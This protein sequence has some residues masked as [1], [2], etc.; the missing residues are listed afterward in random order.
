MKILK[1]GGSSVASPDRI[2]VVEQVVRRE[3][4]KTRVIVV[5]SAFQG[6]TNQLLTCARAAEK[7][8]AE[9]RRLLRQVST[10]HLQTARSLLRGKNRHVTIQVIQGLLRELRE[11]LGGIALLHDCPPRTLDLVASF[12]ERLSSV[13][14]AAYFNQVRPAFAT[15]QTRVCSLS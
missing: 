7:G 2:R 13:I 15:L 5:V 8:D 3:E 4:K 9:Y 12:G 1:F 10:R 14:V 6:V 11:A